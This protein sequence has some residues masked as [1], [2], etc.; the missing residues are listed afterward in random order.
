MSVLASF[1]GVHMRWELQVNDCVDKNEPHV[2]ENMPRISKTYN[3]H[4]ISFLDLKS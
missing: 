3:G 1:L 4:Q 2:L